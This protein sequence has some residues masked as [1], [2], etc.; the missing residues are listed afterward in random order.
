LLDEWLT[1]SFADVDDTSLPYTGYAKVAFQE[2]YLTDLV[3]DPPHDEAT[4]CELLVGAYES[5][6]SNVFNQNIEILAY[7]RL[8]PTTD[9]EV[10]Y[11]IRYRGH[12][13]T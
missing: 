2:A 3:D 6:G 7:R 9:D 13:R 8:G 4:M 10:L 11:E 5:I 12:A 1:R